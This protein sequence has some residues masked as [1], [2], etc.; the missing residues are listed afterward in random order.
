MYYPDS[1]YDSISWTWYY[2][3]PYTTSYNCLGYAT[4]SMTWECPSSWGSG[5]AQAQVETKKFEANSWITE[6]KSLY[7]GLKE[8]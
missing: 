4:G 6:N 2:S 1:F 3:A 8:L 5:A 7:E